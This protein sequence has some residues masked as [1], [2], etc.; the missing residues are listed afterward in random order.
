MFQSKKLDRLSKKNHQG[1]I[2]R[3]SPIKLL[4]LNQIDNII[5]ENDTTS[6]NFGS[7]K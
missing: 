4:D 3:I 2:A 1:V 5:T 7:N 6:S